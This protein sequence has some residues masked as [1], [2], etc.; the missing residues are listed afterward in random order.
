MRPLPE[1]DWEV[2][3]A[4]APC[5]AAHVCH[6]RAIVQMDHSDTPYLDFSRCNGCAKCI[7]ACPWGAI[8]L[9]QLPAI[10]L[11]GSHG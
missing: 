2:C 5:Q 1:I 10:V 3:Q 11:K 4:C 6:M 9:R 8:S 7:S